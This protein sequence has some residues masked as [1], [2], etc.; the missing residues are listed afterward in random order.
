MLEPP[1]QAARLLG[2][3]PVRFSTSLSPHSSQQLEN[4]NMVK[5]LTW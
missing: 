3:L 5:D 1:D 2:T 4:L